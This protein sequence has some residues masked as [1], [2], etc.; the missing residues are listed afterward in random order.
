MLVER[1][2]PNVQVKSRNLSRVFLMQYFFVGFTLGFMCHFTRRLNR[3]FS[4]NDNQACLK[5]IIVI[6]QSGNYTRPRVLSS[7]LGFSK[8]YSAEREIS[9]HGSLGFTVA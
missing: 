1:T 6:K 2:M 5:K 8:F 9:I 4:R 7:G 3:N